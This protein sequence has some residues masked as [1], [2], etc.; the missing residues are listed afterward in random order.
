MSMLHKAYLFDYDAFSRELL[1]ILESALRGG[2]TTQL[3]AFIREHGLDLQDLR[4]GMPFGVRDLP[5]DTPRS[6][7]ELGNIAL[8]KHYDVTRDIGVGVDR[9]ELE[10]ALQTVDG[11]SGIALGRTIGL[12]A[13][14]F[15][16]GRMGS[17]FQS[18]EDVKRHAMLLSYWLSDAPE[19]FEVLDR[20]RDMFQHALAAKT[21]LYITF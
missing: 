1:P 14:P 5:I 6:P 2:A 18:R 10:E 15:D 4:T 8:T 13:H 9:R 3:L 11:Y 19:H 7:Q 21:G 20:L 12:A 17:F 16:P